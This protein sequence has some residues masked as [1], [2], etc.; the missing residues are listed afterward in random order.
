[1]AL[2]V[3]AMLAAP[4]AALAVLWAVLAVLWAMD[5]ASC[6]MLNEQC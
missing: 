5:C 3:W 6:V 4:G 1:M 2:A